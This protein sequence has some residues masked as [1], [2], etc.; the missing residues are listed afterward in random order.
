MEIQK[1][2]DT[3]RR[4]LKPALGCTE[5]IA[6]A[7]AVTYAREAL[8]SLPERIDLAVSCNILKNAMGVGIPG[9]GMVGLEIASALG[10]VAGHSCYGLEVLSD[11][12]P[13]ACAQAR[14]MVDQGCI[15]VMAKE[16]EQKLY[17]EACVSSSGHEAIC[18]IEGTHTHVSSLSCDGRI[19]ARDTSPAMRPA[20]ESATD[21]NID[22]IFSFIQVVEEDQLAF[23]REVIAMNDA[24]ARN[25]LEQDYG[26]RVGKVLQ[27][28]RD[29]EAMSLADYAASY[30]AAA[31]DARMAGCTLP[32]M[33]T[34]G[35]G[36]QGI[37]ASLPVVAAARKM[38]CPEERLLRAEALSQLTTIH[39]KT[40]IGRLSPLCGCAIASSIGSACGVVYLMGGGL[41]QIHFAIQ[42]MIADISGLIC[43]G[44]KSGCALKIASSVAS[45][46]QC[47]QLAMAGVGAS[48]LDGIIAGNVE[49]SIRNLA[50]LG[51]KGMKDTDH[52]ILDMMIAK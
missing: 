31:A 48:S 46:M 47:A 28:G 41:P 17:I 42:N 45:A 4:E 5:P 1:Y 33:S 18:V 16:T 19:L 12:T 51:S 38:G 29:M 20:A 14:E 23:L 8:G 35:S 24:V 32:V 21:M 2:L 26:M 7:L 52:V 9:T 34:A 15:H 37:C 30:T 3:L 49:D 50:S 36:N 22:G 43:D 27:N 11:A 13:E 6:V 39:I 25:G 10:C 44:A 40:H